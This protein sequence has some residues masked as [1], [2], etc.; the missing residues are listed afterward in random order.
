MFISVR[1]EY[2]SKCFV[3]A[4]LNFQCLHS[5]YWGFQDSWK[6]YETVEDYDKP[7]SSLND[8]FDRK[9]DLDFNIKMKPSQVSQVS[10]CQ[11]LDGPQILNEIN[12]PN[13]SLKRMLLD[14]SQASE[15]AR[16]N[17]LGRHNICKSS[18]LPEVIIG[19][20][21]GFTCSQHQVR[22]SILYLNLHPS[23]WCLRWKT[24]P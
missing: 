3:I 13:F 8:L 4:K 2:C 15:T 11:I 9:L 1:R 20:V 22:K 5:G 16:R 21:I 23:L 12:D 17:N 24:I 6:D 7:S 18:N 19:E 14:P 10:D